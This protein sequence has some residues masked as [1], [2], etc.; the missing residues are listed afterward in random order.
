MYAP[1]IKR[2]FK[3][4]GDLPRVTAPIPI[5]H[6]P[7]AKRVITHTIALLMCFTTCK[8]FICRTT[9]THVSLRL[10]P[11]GLSIARK[12]GISLCWPPVSINGLI[13]DLSGTHSSIAL[14]LRR[15]EKEI[16]R[17]IEGKREKEADKRKEDNA[18]RA[19]S[20]K[21][22]EEVHDS[23]SAAHTAMRVGGYLPG[24]IAGL[25]NI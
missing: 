15:G 5:P 13:A 16:E 2:T 3:D 23:E 8:Q 20:S 17:E 24:T 11:M 9:K 6:M 25:H 12:D 21:A 19:P 1:F 10:R 4:S 14:Y 18:A 7:R 22:H